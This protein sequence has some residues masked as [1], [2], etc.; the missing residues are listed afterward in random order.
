LEDPGVDG[1][2]IVKLICKKW[3]G[4]TW[5]GLLWLRIGTGDR[6]L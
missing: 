5:N 1:R 6:L 3:V 2:I 4:E